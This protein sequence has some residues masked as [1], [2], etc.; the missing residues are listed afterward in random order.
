M[1]LTGEP[2]GIIWT[3][4]IPKSAET[5]NSKNLD[6]WLRTKNEKIWKELSYAV[7]AA[8]IREVLQKYLTDSPQ[9]PRD[10]AETIS[11]MIH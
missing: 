5:Q 2:V 7:P 8:K 9:L 4:R 3:G 6:D 1:P 11:A 10:T